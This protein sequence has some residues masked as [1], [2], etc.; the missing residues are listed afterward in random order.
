MPPPFET[1]G[2]SRYV[3]NASH[4]DYIYI[5]HRVTGQV[6][7]N[8]Y[9]RRQLGNG[10][11]GQHGYYMLTTDMN[12]LEAAKKTEKG[13]VAIRIPSPNNDEEVL[14]FVRIVEP[15]K[16]SD[17]KQRDKNALTATN[18]RAS[19]STSRSTSNLQSIS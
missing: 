14:F 5:M 19:D 15:Q 3:I 13:A 4:R 7:P 12:L 8:L 1:T 11:G 9:M 6:E 2:L 17:Y 18:Y 10:D 16:I